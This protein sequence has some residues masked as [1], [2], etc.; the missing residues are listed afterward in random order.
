MTRFIIKQHQKRILLIEPPFYRLYESGYA[1]VKY[2]LSLA[3]LA[4]AVREYTDW[5]VRAFNADFAPVSAPFDITWMTG[6]GYDRYM[7]NLENPSFGIWSAIRSVLSAYRPSVIG[8]S[9]KSSSLTAAC[10]IASIA[11]NIDPSSIIVVG[12]PHPSATGAEMLKNSD[13][14]I[15]VAGEGETTLV[16]LLQAIEAGGSLDGIDSLFFRNGTEYRCTPPRA[17][18]AIL[19]VPGFPFQYAQETLIGCEDYPSAAFSYI[20]AT[21]GC[22]HHCLFC[23]SREIWGRK[24]RFRSPEHV[25]A[26][27]TFLRHMGVTS[28]HF[29]DDTFGVTSDYL[30]RLCHTLQRL[31]P[32]IVWSCEIH[33]RLV[34]DTH[35][36]LMKKAGCRMIQ[37][38]IESGNNGILKNIRKGFVIGE[39][40]AAC[41]LIVRH[42]IRL[43]TFFMAGFPWETETTLS[44]TRM[45]MEAIE[46]EKIIYSLFTPY[47]GTEAFRLCQMQG[48]IPER[49]SPAL[50]GHQSPRNCFCLH[51]TSERF[52]AISR[53]MEALVVKKNHAGRHAAAPDP[54]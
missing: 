54:L 5:D 3:C 9:V 19:D 20:F 46:C 47:P 32:G 26:E 13:I 49:Y 16:E 17:L 34:N 12:G 23:G 35:I 4:F 24:P 2:P 15:C 1:L 11:K 6:G 42:G 37:L 44:D 36:R 8:I 18:S 40:L 28:F 29:D 22:P 50:F 38:G 10:R 53:D 30:Q 48:L 21:R 7:E 27:I 45:V 39:A 33:V 25:A 14:D 51:L 41:R 52:R 31:C 43:H